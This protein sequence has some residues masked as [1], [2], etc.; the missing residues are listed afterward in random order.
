MNLGCSGICT[1]SVWEIDMPRKKV[2][3]PARPCTCGR[4]IPMGTSARVTRC[5]YCRAADP[6]R[7]AHRKGKTL[8][9]MFV[10]IDSEGAANSDTDSTQRML[11]MS[12]GREDGTSGTIQTESA[13][14]AIKWLMGHVVGKYTDPSGQEY[15]QITVAFHFNYDSAVLLKDFVATGPM[16]T[17]MYEDVIEVAP[18]E[19][20]DVMKKDVYPGD[21]M[22]LVR[23]AAKRVTTNLCGSN[24]AEGEPCE[25]EKSVANAMEDPE[26]E[27]KLEGTLHRFSAAACEAVMTD[28]GEADI[29]AFDPNSR[30]ALATTPGR[31][32][33]AEMRPLGDLFKG[34]KILDIHDTGTAMPGGL[35]YNIDRWRPEL[36]TDQREIIAWGKKTRVDN[37]AEYDL[38]KV[39]AYSEA[40]CVAHARICR[41]LVKLVK[42]AGHIELPEKKLYGSG[43]I[44]QAALKFYGV[45]KRETVDLGMDPLRYTHGKITPNQVSHLTY[46]GGMIETPV[47]GMV[48]G[49]VDEVDINSAYPSKMVD[50]PCMREKHGKWVRG[51]KKSGYS[52][53]AVVG[54][55]RA[56]WVIPEELVGSTPPFV[57]RMPNGNVAQPRCAQEPVWVSLAEYEAAITQYGPY[58]TMHEVLY[59]DEEC[60]CG[61]PLEWLADLYNK[62]REIKA[63]MKTVDRES[64]EW[65]HWDREQDVIKLIINSIYGKLAQQEPDFG[66]YTNLH[67]ASYITGATRAQ[68]RME[69][70]DRERQGG[71]VVYQHTDSVLSI[72][73][74]P[75]DGGSDLGAWGLEDKATKDFLIMQPGLATGMGGGKTATRGCREHDFVVAAKSWYKKADLTQH[76][77]KWEPMVV[78]QR[79][80]Y[81]R[82]LAHA[83]GKPHLAGSFQPKITNIQAVSPKRDIDR[84]V[85]LPGMPTAWAVPPLP[86]LEAQASLE[87]L[88]T[89][90]SAV[91]RQMKAGEFDDESA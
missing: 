85:Q 34:R 9:K 38:R 48:S 4:E 46:F 26:A 28:G 45:S 19:Y 61:H 20:I 78:K 91:Q 75:K 70:W 14:R 8:P 42:E 82:R 55:V 2:I 27:V 86:V 41:M 64:N 73:G 77:T 17:E 79:V 58:I 40:E 60:E 43:S 49:S 83:L 13:V 59:W 10:S 67:W 30:L 63:L 90:K 23:K 15:D 39:G 35:E 33:Y 29:L 65:F 32:F 80:M 5:D 47:V 52:P 31:R 16:Q 66:T 6:H 84:A 54:H 1:T 36:T 12:Y 62:R 25:M 18:G 37:L 22:Y 89:Y 68:V 76:P 21:P 71:K 50:L 53:N 11:T 88:K 74:Q 51:T 56:S 69:T 81:T 87:D 44:A 72:G 57:V 3:R 24:H 7:N